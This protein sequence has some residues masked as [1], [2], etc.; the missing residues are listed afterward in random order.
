M[1]RYIWQVFLGIDKL[2]NAILGP[3]LNLILK[4]PDVAEFGD[5][6]QTLSA[7]FGRNIRAGRCKVCK[8]ICWL[9]D[10]LDPRPG[11]HCELA[12]RDDLPD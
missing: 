2:A 11:N 6:R 9:L 5:H 8:G 10:I 12:I 3:L 4:T 1:K 7:V